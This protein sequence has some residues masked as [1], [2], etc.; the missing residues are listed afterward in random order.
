MRVTDPVITIASD[1]ASLAVNDLNF[2]YGYE[3]TVT[4]DGEDEWA[5][6]ASINHQDVMRLST[7]DLDAHRNSGDV[8][9]YLLLGI[10]EY[11]KEILS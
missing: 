5:F 3:E 6:V 4:V 11:L 10:G 2:Y 9:E 8:S 7:T 1:Y